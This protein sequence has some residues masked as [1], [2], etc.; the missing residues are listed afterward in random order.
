[1]NF[2]QVLTQVNLSLFVFVRRAG[3]IDS[4]V[5]IGPCWDAGKQFLLNEGSGL[6][7]RSRRSFSSTNSSN[8]A[9]TSWRSLLESANL[10]VA[11]ANGDV[12]VARYAA[13]MKLTFKL[14]LRTE[15]PLER[16]QVF[17]TYFERKI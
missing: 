7:G 5:M 1:M 10:Q 8:S 3:E 13:L 17:E 11:C 6:N 14:I 4:S 2:Q 15:N 9:F 16:E 12:D